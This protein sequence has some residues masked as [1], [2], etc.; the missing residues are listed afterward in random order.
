[1]RHWLTRMNPALHRDE[2]ARPVLGT[3]ELCATCHAQFMEEDL[4]HWGWVKMQDEYTAWRNSPFSGLNS[5]AFGHQE[6]LDCVDCHMD[7]VQSDDPSRNAA[8]TVAGHFFPAA[9]TVVARHFGHEQQQARTRDFLRGNKIS[10]SIEEPNRADAAQTQQALTEDIRSQSETPFFYYL[11]ETAELSVIL[12]NRGVGHNF[13][14]GTVDINE[15][16]VSFTVVDGS[17]EVVFASG[18]IT[19]DGHAPLAVDPKAYFYRS[20]PVDR[21]GDLVWR[22]DLFNRVGEAE[23]RVI[24]AG[25][26]DLLHYRFKVPDWAKSPL[27][28]TATLN[29]R[30]LND[31]YARWALG[32]A[33]QPIPVVDMARDSLIIPL[34]TRDL[35]TAKGPVSSR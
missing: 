25:K 21:R 33:Y 22:H 15:A 27:T 32:N 19:G 23:K 26:S 20:R 9:N 7:Q 6:Q 4:N 12:G 29:Y 30:K 10:I 3:A 24:P 18:A 1:M 11:G 34:Y 8:G 16:W 13:P 5:E 28:V 14:G 17:G 31:R 35:V 2:M